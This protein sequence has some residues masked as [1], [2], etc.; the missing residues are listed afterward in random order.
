MT[1]AEDR[2]PPPT[3]W[4]GVGLYAAADHFPLGRAFGRVERSPETASGPD[5]RPFGL[6][7]A[8]E[9][10]ATPV[11]LATF[12]YDPIRQIGLLRAGGTALPLLRH[13]TGTTSTK[14]SDGHQGM[15]SDSDQR[16]DD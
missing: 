7:H 2:H 14:T 12:E 5:S 13:T 8:V 10:P 11:D 16:A 3:G 1:A 9:P 4:S 6:R 15:D